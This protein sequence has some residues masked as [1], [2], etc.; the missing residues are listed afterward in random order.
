MGNGPFSSNPFAIIPRFFIDNSELVPEPQSAVDSRRRMSVP[1]SLLAEK[2][3][4][5]EVDKYAKWVR[6]RG[7]APD[8]QIAD[9]G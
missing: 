7:L 3:T 1:P 9:P 5:D 2:G 8:A 4:G 6:L